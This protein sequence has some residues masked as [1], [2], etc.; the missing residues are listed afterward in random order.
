VI[1]KVRRR[2][3]RQRAREKRR[4]ILCFRHLIE[5]KHTLGTK[6]SLFGAS[7]VFPVERREFYNSL[8]V[9]LFLPIIGEKSF[10]SQTLRRIDQSDEVRTGDL[11]LQNEKFANF[12]RRGCFDMQHFRG[13]TC[14]SHWW[15]HQSVGEHPR[16]R[17]LTFFV[18]LREGRFFLHH[19]RVSL[20]QKG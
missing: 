16:S 20:R 19:F 9:K 4:G 18:F 17:R 11:S 12:L 1:W 7:C 2:E 8:Q 6:N 10:W 3:C 14:D 5:G 13:G 15:S